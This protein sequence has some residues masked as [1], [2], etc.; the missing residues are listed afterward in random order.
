MISTNCTVESTL[1]AAKTQFQGE[2]PSRSG[3]LMDA[4]S[5]LVAD[6]F[7]GRHP[8]YQKADLM[9]HDL[10]HTL[11]A[12][13]CFI[14]LA[15]GL[16]QKAELTPLSAHQYALGYA[17]IMLHD[18]G[19]LKDRNDMS[20]TGAKYTASHVERSCTLAAELLPH[21]G[22]S[23]AEITGIANA[24]RCTGL[25]SQIGLINFTSEAERL[26]GCMVATADYLGQMADPDYPAK[27]PCLFAEFEESND[28]NNVPAEKRLF[29]TAKELM[30]KTSGFWNFF[31]LPKLEK[32]YEGVY[33]WLTKPDGRNPYTEAVTVNLARIEKMAAE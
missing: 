7:G 2:L 29:R 31:A 30:A 15:L 12:T 8:N 14:D 13:T 25:T 23:P 17:A 1:A 19:Y 6:L 5:V 28:F 32:D 11:K 4:V 3:Q 27:L 16:S 22:C 33:R 10:D 20:G 9:Y 21:L 24:I 26:T 18:C